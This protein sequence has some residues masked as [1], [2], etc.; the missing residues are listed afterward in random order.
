M[1]RGRFSPPLSCFA[2]HFRVLAHV[3]VSRPDCLVEE[4]HGPDVLFDKS[5]D[6]GLVGESILG[7]F[8]H[9]ARLVSRSI[10]Q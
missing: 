2:D 10:P 6:I 3:L 5:L 8:G 7:P 9:D 1:S 4:G